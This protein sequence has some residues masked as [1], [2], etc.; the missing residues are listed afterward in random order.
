MAHFEKPAGTLAAAYDIDNKLAPGSVWRMRVPVDGRA[1]IALY[2]GD[3]LW[4]HSNNA[5]VVPEDKISERPSAGR[6]ILSLFG[7]SVGTSMVDVGQNGSPWATLQVQ[8]VAAGAAAGPVFV[9]GKDEDKSGIQFTPEGNVFRVELDE[10]AKVI[11]GLRNG[12]GLTVVSNNKPVAEVGVEGRQG[13]LRTYSI[14]T[15]KPGDAMIEARTANGAAL[16]SFQV[17]VNAAKSQYGLIAWGPE[18]TRKAAE[19]LQKTRNTPDPAPFPSQFGTVFLKRGLISENR[20][21]IIYTDW[22][23]TIYMTGDKLYSVKTTDFVRNVYLD[24][25]A[26][27]ANRAKHWIPISQVLMDFVTGLL[28]GPAVI[29]AGYVVF[30]ALFAASHEELVKRGA[31]ALGPAYRGLNDFKQRYPALWAKIKQKIGQQFEADLVDGLKETVTDPKNIAFYLGRVL[32]H[33]PSGPTGMEPSV[34]IGKILFVVVECAVLVTAL[35]SPVGLFH[36]ATGQVRELANNLK[37]SFQKPELGIPLSDQEALSI[38]S[39]LLRDSNR[40]AL[41]KDLNGSLTD[42][43]ALLEKFESELKNSKQ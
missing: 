22:Q 12:A 30:G 6:R 34:P 36:A 20:N 10:S 5:G 15:L 37:A 11:V 23:V 26:D 17:H 24:A 4:V 13:D 3:G 9:L 31:N 33:M 39:E 32:R 8:V 28:V 25:L 16:A 7:R 14:V 1:E 40:D 18:A 21:L 41:L 2:G 43:K 29:I 19:I 35:H 27:G 42:L 38:A